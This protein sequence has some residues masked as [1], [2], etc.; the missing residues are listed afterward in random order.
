[1]CY[2][3]CFSAVVF[4]VA[5]LVDF[6]I[7]FV[8]NFVVDFD[9]AFVIDF[10]VGFYRCWLRSCHKIHFRHLIPPPPTP[11]LASTRETTVAL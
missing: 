9:V 1:M 11:N 4:V 3:W 5:F 8:I 10:A 7:D 6:V 2:P